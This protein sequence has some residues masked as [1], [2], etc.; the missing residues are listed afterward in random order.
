M[1]RVT[2]IINNNDQIE[3]NIIYAMMKEIGIDNVFLE[4]DSPLTLSFNIEENKSFE[5]IDQINESM[6]ELLDL[7][8]TDYPIKYSVA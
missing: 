3:P 6:Q 8:D 2:L 7:V 1:K 4:N 5:V